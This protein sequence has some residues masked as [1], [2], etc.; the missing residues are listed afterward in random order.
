M[1][2]ANGPVGLS[3]IQTW[4]IGGALMSMAPRGQVE[5]GVMRLNSKPKGVKQMFSCSCHAVTGPPGSGP[6]T[7][8]VFIWNSAPSSPGPC[9]LLA[10][11]RP[12]GCCGS[13]TYPDA[14]FRWFIQCVEGSVWEPPGR[15]P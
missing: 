9:L 6:N 8:S 15:N 7:P 11:T 14:T 12:C 1:S 3:T 5:V 2:T 10:Y 4:S 13:I